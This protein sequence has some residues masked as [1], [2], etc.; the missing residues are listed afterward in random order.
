MMLIVSET[1]VRLG[2]FILGCSAVLC[3]ISA[4]TLYP[5]D[6]YEQPPIEYSRSTPDNRVSDLQKSIERQ[7]ATLQ[8]DAQFGYLRDLLKHLEIRDDSQMLVFSKTSMQRDRISPRRPRAIYFNDDSYVGYCLNGDVIEIST[9]D[10]KLGI[11]F[12]TID[13]RNLE[14]PTITRQTHNC[15]QCHGSTQTEGI[16]GHVVRS[17]FVE[18]SGLPILSEGSHRVDHTTPFE[19]RWGGWYVSGTHGTQTHM[20][21]FIVRDKKAERPWKNEEGQ[22]IT[23]L[24][25]RFP[26]QNYLNAHSDIVALMVFEHQTHVQN[27][28]IKANFATRQAL[29]YE[30]GLNEALGKPRDHRL[31]STTRRIQNAGEKLLEGLLMVDE[32][33]LTG[34][35]VGTSGFAAEFEKSGL[36]DSQGRSLRDLDLQQRLFKHPCSYL[37]Y[38]QAFDELPQEMKAYVKKRLP[39]ILAGQGG[40]RYASLSEEDRE[41]ISTILKET[42]RELM[43]GE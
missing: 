33:A 4:A 41:A 20:G 17:L 8:H 40:E 36:R 6:E 3:G 39:E 1:F 26:A 18:P 30:Q 19:N 14:A 5:T 12:Y 43:Q 42:K 9:M 25:D 24:T 16:P 34:P 38:S 28:M 31:E 2:K 7:E 21:N 10:P 35:V 15:L 22:N 13:Q 27:L 32:A 23:H 37:I 29:H 11:I